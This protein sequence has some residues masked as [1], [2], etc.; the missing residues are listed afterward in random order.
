[1]ESRCPA[2]ELRQKA[3]QGFLAALNEPEVIRDAPAQWLVHIGYPVLR[4]SLVSTQSRDGLARAGVALDEE[5]LK[6]PQQLMQASSNP[7]IAIYGHL[8]AMRITD[9]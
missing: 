5:Y 9:E 6:L 4:S 7:I 8:A 1:M 3:L 2:G